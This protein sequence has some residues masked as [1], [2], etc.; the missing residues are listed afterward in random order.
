[1]VGSGAA[2]S[3]APVEVFS[4]GPTPAVL[5]AAGFTEGLPTPEAVQ[6]H[7]DSSPVY[8]DPHEGG[9]WVG[10]EPREKI[11]HSEGLPRRPSL[12]VLKVVGGEVHLWNG[13]SFT[14][15]LGKTRWGSRTW[16]RPATN[17]G[18]PVP[19]ED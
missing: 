12:M 18:L 1:M 9:V 4:Q 6:A 14:Q 10:I 8:G 2:G 5:E 11:K 7:A 19:S 15:P 16:Y 13:Y 3:E 17:L